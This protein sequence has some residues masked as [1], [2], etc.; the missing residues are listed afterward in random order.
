MRP[1]NEFEPIPPPSVDLADETA[2]AI[3]ARV[4]WFAGAASLL[5]IVIIMV[6]VAPARLMKTTFWLFIFALAAFYQA[7]AKH[8][9][10]QFLRR[11][12]SAAQIKLPPLDTDISN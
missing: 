9:R 10:V 4:A 2:K 8:R 7:C 12:M 11:R 1:N 5:A 6:Y 3:R